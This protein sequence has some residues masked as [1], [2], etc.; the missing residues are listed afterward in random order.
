MA[1]TTRTVEV[2]RQPET[3]TFIDKEG[4][5]R[6]L[7][8]IFTDEFAGENV[9]KIR[10]QPSHW[11]R[12][13]K[14]GNEQPYEFGFGS[15]SLTVINPADF[16]KPL[17]DSGWQIRDQY[18]G[19]GGSALNTTYILPDRAYDD[20][21]HFDREL[22]GERGDLNSLHV[23]VQMETNIRPGH[24]AVRITPGL[25]RLVCTNGLIARVMG[26]GSFE[27]K[28][29]EGLNNFSTEELIARVH[30]MTA[31][32]GS[33]PQGAYLGSARTL[34]KANDV[35]KRFYDETFVNK[36]VSPA[37]ELLGKSFAVFS[38]KGYNAINSGMT[39]GFIDMMDRVVSQGRD[40]YAIDVLN[41]Y[42]SAVNLRRAGAVNGGANF[43]AFRALQ[44]TEP[45]VEA[46]A[47]MS[48]IAQ[49]FS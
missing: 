23:A 31:D 35:L 13:D 39:K 6:E 1:T 12:T 4:V 17:L 8:T 42:T 7:G 18:Q 36:N 48:A 25:F 37:M 47:Q 43:S 32:F 29:A 15:G 26:L 3:L 38:A 40:V 27:L 10:W 24:M 2:T 19:F 28:H 49:L 14:D 46:V 11:R 45:V 5:E 20:P 33:L 22:W 41:A 9:R 34:A 21:Y 16:Q 30:G 44:A